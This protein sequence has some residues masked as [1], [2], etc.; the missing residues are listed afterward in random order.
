MV[1]GITAMNGTPI[2]AAKYASE[3]AVEP[4]DAST[5]GRPG[6]IHPLHRACRNS[7]RAS[8]CFRLPVGWVDSSFRYRATSHDGGNGKRS[9]WVSAL[10]LASARTRRTARWSHAR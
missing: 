8:R 5:T 9:M 7:D 1:L 10:R 4:L 3:M 2:N 6:R